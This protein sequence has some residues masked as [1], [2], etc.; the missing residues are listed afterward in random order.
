MTGP[1]EV[2]QQF[3]CALHRL[4]FVDHLLIERAFGGAQ[5]IAELLLDLCAGEHLH[6]A[7]AANADRA[8][9]L[10]D[11]NDHAVLAKGSIPR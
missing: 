4:D 7:V 10:P 8:V 2:V 3:V 5:R 11:R 9:D 1:F 6:D